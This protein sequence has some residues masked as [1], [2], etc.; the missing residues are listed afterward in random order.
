MAQDNIWKKEKKETQLIGKKLISQPE[1]KIE[2]IEGSS[3]KKFQTRK[4]TQ[5]MNLGTRQHFLTDPFY[6][7]IVFIASR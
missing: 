1:R 7:H 6:D 2:S 5:E 4:G 3:N